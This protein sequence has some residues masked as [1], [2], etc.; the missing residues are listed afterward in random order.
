VKNDHRPAPNSS[1]PPHSLKEKTLNDG[2]KS[3]STKTRYPVRLRKMFGPLPRG[4][5]EMCYVPLDS[6]VVH[7]FFL[8]RVAYSKAET[9]IGTG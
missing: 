4:P 8:Q 2:T 6:G 1:L 5:D 9:G 3:L 7:L